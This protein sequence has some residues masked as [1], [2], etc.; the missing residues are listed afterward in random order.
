M[1]FCCCCTGVVI[2]G[3]L[4]LVPGCVCKSLHS[5]CSN[6][7]RCFRWWQRL[8]VF[9]DFVGHVLDILCSAHC[10]V[11]CQTSK[12]P[13]Y[14]HTTELFGPFLSTMSSLTPYFFFSFFNTNSCRHGSIPAMWLVQWRNSHRHWL[15]ILSVKRWTNVI[16]HKDIDHVSYFYRYIAQP[17]F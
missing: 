6:G 13:K 9:P 15:F 5:P 7:W 10:S 8:V 12:K 11:S 16:Y 3:R 4:A 2:G 1:A 17:Y 14:L